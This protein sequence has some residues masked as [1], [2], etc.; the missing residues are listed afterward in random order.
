MIQNIY[1][2]ITTGDKKGDGA[3]VAGQKINSNFAYLENKIDN[4]A[5]LIS[6]NGFSLSGQ[7]ITFNMGWFWK[8][9]NF[10]YSNPQDVL[11]NVPFAEAG[12]TRIDIIVMNTSNTFIRIA[13][14]ESDSNPVSPLVPAGTIQATFFIVQELVIEDPAEPLV[15]EIP[16]PLRSLFTLLRKDSNSNNTIELND[17]AHGFGPGSGEDLEYWPLA[18]FLNLTGDNNVN[19]YLN[20]KPISVSLP[21]S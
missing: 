13:G 15:G 6:S 20:Y 1:L 17:L 19:N 11:I 3:K 14:I 7:N 5:V 8:I 4:K 9:N 12:K 16:P 21:N 10:T 18:K 2:G